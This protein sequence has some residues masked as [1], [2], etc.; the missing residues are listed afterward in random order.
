MNDVLFN[1]VDLN[2]SPYKTGRWKEI[3]LHDESNIKGFFGNEYRFLSNFWPVNIFGFPSVE[4]AYMAAKVVPEDRE[5]FKTCSPT[6]AKRNWKRFKLKDSAPSNWDARKFDV[7]ARCIFE[8]FLVDKE[9]RGK[10]ID[11]GDKYLEERN[12]WGDA[13]WGVDIKKGG[14]NNLG[15]ILMGT[16]EFWKN[17]L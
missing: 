1:E 16:R 12:W 5:F 8:K 13:V 15:K 6:E 2:G 17:N 7:M 3:C 10:L 9:L 11:T 14:K 4:N